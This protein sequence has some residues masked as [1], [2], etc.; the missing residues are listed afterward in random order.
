MKALNLGLRDLEAAAL[1]SSLRL[2]NF[3]SSLQVGFSP[4]Q[5]SVNVVSA[6]MTTAGAAIGEVEFNAAFA[7]IEKQLQALNIGGQDVSKFTQSLKA[8][9]HAQRNMG[10]IFDDDFKKNMMAEMGAGGMSTDKLREV[11]AN[12]LGDSLSA[13]GFGDE[14]RKGI[15]LSL[16]HI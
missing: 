8:M 9:A 1:A 14:A 11:L 5:N 4:L 13:A 3:M 7:D 6:A 15:M 12:K 2:N 16:I 10:A